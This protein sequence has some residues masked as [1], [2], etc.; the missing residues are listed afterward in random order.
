MFGAPGIATELILCLRQRISLRR[1]GRLNAFK[2]IGKR[3]SRGTS[4]F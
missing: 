1:P 2:K 3:K 4:D